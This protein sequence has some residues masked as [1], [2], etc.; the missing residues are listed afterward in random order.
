MRLESLRGNWVKVRV[1]S[2]KIN[3]VYLKEKESAV[4]PLLGL[5]PLVGLAHV[6]DMKLKYYDLIVQL[7][8]QDDNYLEACS[9]YQ[10]VW[11]TEEIKKDEGRE[12]NV[13]FA[14]LVESS[15]ERLTRQVLENIM[16]YVVLAPYNN[17]QS[18]MLHKLFADSALQKSPVY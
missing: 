5:L 10:E 6:Q 12:I 18:D 4:R 7:A 14:I 15:R 8:L 13:S 17:E 1:G 3:R 2:R 9:A 11:D 16:T